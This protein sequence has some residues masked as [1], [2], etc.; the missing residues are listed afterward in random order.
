MVQAFPHKHQS[1]EIQGA[2][3]GNVIRVIRYAPMLQDQLLSLIIEKIIQVDV[4]IQVEIEDLQHQDQPELDQDVFALDL[5]QP[6]DLGDSSNT[7]MVDDDSN[8]V[9]QA[10]F[11]IKEMLTKLDKMLYK[12][13]KYLNYSITSKD[14]ERH[15]FEVLLSVFDKHILLTF[16][17]RYTQFLLFYFCSKE[18]SYIDRFLGL[19]ISNIQDVKVP[20]VTRCASASYLGSFVARAKYLNFEYIR[21]VMSLLTGWLT[22]YIEQNETP[23]SLPDP[24]K[25]AVFYAASQSA[26]YLFCFR[27]RSFLLG[28]LELSEAFMQGKDNGKELW[29][30]CVTSIRHIVLSR[31][32]PLMI[33]APLV[34]QQFSK[35]AKQV[36][37]M[38]SF[39]IIE[40][41]RKMFLPHLDEFFKNRDDS[42]IFFPFDPY[43][44]QQTSSFIDPLY[45]QWN[46]VNSHIELNSDDEDDIGNGKN[47]TYSDSEDEIDLGVSLMAMS[48]SPAMAPYRR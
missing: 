13:F 24:T 4:E 17:S 9:I 37:F 38:Y 7:N 2:Y 35:I 21:M 22:D 42:D 26:L 1:A 25:H 33:V 10:H 30:P 41:N 27:W 39:S 40:S 43:Q 23:A 46:D 14:E 20:Q 44:L 8:E 18:Q 45:Q 34:T 29:H 15:I 6:G 12:V 31:L 3:V 47:M 11:D 32:N 48:L 36:D 28:G 5:N 16:K 19:L